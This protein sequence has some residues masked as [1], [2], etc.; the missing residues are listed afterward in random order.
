MSK[1]VLFGR[2]SD[3][4]SPGQHYRIYRPEDRAHDTLTHSVQGPLATISCICSRA[5]EIGPCVYLAVLIN[6]K[7]ADRFKQDEPSKGERLIVSLLAPTG[8]EFLVAWIACI[9]LGHGVVFI[10]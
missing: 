4:V 10:A 8:P 7:G 1:V 2:A 3:S 6:R 5:E 9:G